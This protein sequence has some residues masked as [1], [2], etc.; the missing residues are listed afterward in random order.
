M[1]PPCMLGELE[2]LLRRS[3]SEDDDERKAAEQIIASSSPDPDFAIALLDLAASA[4]HSDDTRI[5]ASFLFSSVLRRRWPSPDADADAG[6]QPIDRAI[7]KRRLCN[8]FMGA[9]PSVQA[10]LAEALGAA[11]ASDPANWNPRVLPSVLSCLSTAVREGNLAASNA[12]LAALSA[13][14]S[15]AVCLDPDFSLQDFAGTHTTLFEAACRHI[16]ENKTMAIDLRPVFELARICSETFYWLR[17]KHS[18]DYLKG[19]LH[20]WMAQFYL[21]LTD[22]Y[23]HDVEADGA[24]DA[25]RAVAIENLLLN[26]EKSDEFRPPIDAVWVLLREG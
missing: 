18:P 15:R 5:D 4:S 23:H 20:E 25:L 12:S 8:V 24:P 9:P 16:Q 26:M 17:S 7:I 21:F 6:L 10:Q 1:A 3:H 14:F 22:R 2:S 13:F 19:K 11:A